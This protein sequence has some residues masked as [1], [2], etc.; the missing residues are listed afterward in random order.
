MHRKLLN[1][2]AVWGYI[3]AL[4]IFLG[5]AGMVPSPKYT[6]GRAKAPAG[7]TAGEKGEKPDDRKGVDRKQTIASKQRPRSGDA[8]DREVNSWWGTPYMLGGQRRNSGIDC[9]GYTQAVY[10]AVYGIDLPRNS[11]KQYRSGTAISRNRLRRGDL[12]F[13]NLNG[14]GVSHVGIYLGAGKFTHA[15]LSDGVTI[16]ELD[17]A[18]FRKKFV[19]AR[20]YR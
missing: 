1:I 7:R 11:A 15:S 18:Y 6:R 9:S 14:R 2:I 19:G 5:C 13:F 17:N 16:D 20:R 12:L 4:S 3:F 10:K 8:L